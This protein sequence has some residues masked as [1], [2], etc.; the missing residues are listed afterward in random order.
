MH[1]FGL[2]AGLG[3][4]LLGGCSSLG[5]LS[6]SSGGAGGPALLTT[7]LGTALFALDVPVSVE[8][9]PP[10]LRLV[11]TVPQDRG[12]EAVLVRADAEPV[13][14]ALPPPA[15]GRTY[16]VYALSEADRAA[17]AAL[18]ARLAA[19]PAPAATLSIVPLLCVTPGVDPAKERISVLPVIGGAALHPIVDAES[20][21]S[22]AARAGAPLPAC[23]GHSG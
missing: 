4:L 22:I 7:D 9:V 5:G 17:V 15:E 10:G 21:A 16:F 19:M 6:P 12:L 8:P 14:A 3:A 11:V 23:A 2:L 20:L 18:Q 1:R 13:M